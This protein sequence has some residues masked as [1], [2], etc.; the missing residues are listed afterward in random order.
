M[1]VKNPNNP[2]YMYCGIVQRITDGK[3]GVIFEGGHWDRLVTFGLEEV[4]R[5]EK[6]PPGTNPKSVVLEPLSEEL[7]KQ[8][9]YIVRIIH[10]NFWY[11]L[12][13]VNCLIKLYQ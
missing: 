10:L 4:E 1:L 13:V 11:S 2:F 7:E 3:A 6:G 8:T 5:R 9:T 12:P